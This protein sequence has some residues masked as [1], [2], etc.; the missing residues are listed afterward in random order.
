MYCN[1]L[2]TR[3]KINDQKTQEK[4]VSE[5]KIF[6]DNISSVYRVGTW[7]LSIRLLNILNESFSVPQKIRYS[8]F[9]I[10]F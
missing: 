1:L 2:L 10:E 4:N 7:N 6:V 3:G 8:L 5:D 9:E